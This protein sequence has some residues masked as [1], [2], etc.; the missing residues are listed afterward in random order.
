ML[1]KQPTLC[2][3]ES[4]MIQEK[5]ESKNCLKFVVYMSSNHQNFSIFGSTD[6]YNFFLY[7]TTVAKRQVSLDWSCL[8][9][10]I[11][12]FNRNQTIHSKVFHYVISYIKFTVLL[13]LWQEQTKLFKIFIFDFQI[14]K[15]I[16]AFAKEISQ[17]ISGKH[18]IW[19]AHEDAR[20]IPRKTNRKLTQCFKY[21][22]MVD[23]IDF[24]PACL[25]VSCLKTPKIQRIAHHWFVFFHCYS[26]FIYLVKA[27]IQK[28]KKIM[29]IYQFCQLLLMMINTG[30]KFT[31]S[32][33]FPY[34]YVSF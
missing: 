32:I 25:N 26:S 12:T 13:F 17:S 10:N 20:K 27:K 1:S 7:D 9:W 28:K 8:K 21:K 4:S 14:A 30:I 3:E 33:L 16:A 2:Q 24:P 11:S 31:E 29:L 22:R 34:L 19:A 15:T 6:L 5:G 18:L 23:N